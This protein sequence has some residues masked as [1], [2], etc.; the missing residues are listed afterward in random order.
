MGLLLLASVS[1]VAIAQTSNTG[2]LTGVVTDPSNA[3]LADADVQIKDN[4]KGATQSTRTD[5]WGMYRFFFVA[6][7]RYTLIVSHPGFREESQDVNLLLGPPGT[8]NNTLAIAGG[9]STVDVT[10]AVPLL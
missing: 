2:E 4:A 10:D 5:Q 9:V 7:G 3:V 8:R 6:P 1:R